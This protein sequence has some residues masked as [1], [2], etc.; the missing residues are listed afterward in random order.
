M[1]RKPQFAFELDVSIDKE[2]GEPQAAYFKVRENRVA[3]T[4]EVG[5]GAAFVDLDYRGRLVGVE[6]LQPCEVKVLDKVALREPVEFRR[7][8][9]T[10]LR[11][12]IPRGMVMAH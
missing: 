12:Q 1:S 8:V 9:R 11:D 10:F 7:P 2:T 4:E 3:R 6:L 5:D